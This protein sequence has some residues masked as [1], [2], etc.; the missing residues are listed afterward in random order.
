LIDS[1]YVGCCTDLPDDIAALTAMLIEAQAREV[2]KDAQ[3][4]RL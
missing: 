4:E 1:G 3:I 2:R